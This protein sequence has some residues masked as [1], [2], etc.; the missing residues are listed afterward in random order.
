MAKYEIKLRGDFVEFINH[1]DEII[2]NRSLS[3][4]FEDGN[5]VNLG[6]TRAA[7]RVYERYSY[8]GGNRVSM[9]VTVVEN[10]SDIHLTAITSGGSQAVFFKINTIGENTFLGDCVYAVEDYIE[11]K[12]K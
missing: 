8:F 9:N 4:H 2:M 1:I 11:K 7:I 10:E 12:D 5:D 6:G 3:V